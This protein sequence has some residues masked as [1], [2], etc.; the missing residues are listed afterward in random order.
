MSRAKAR[1]G[2]AA[3]D[4]AAA[5]KASRLTGGDDVRISI[6]SPRAPWP[7]SAVPTAAGM[8]RSRAVRPKASPPIA[9]ASGV[10]R[11]VPRAGRAAAT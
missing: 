6:L 9:T 10:I 1:T 5:A 11:G 3:R 2:M 7:S 4:P 8:T